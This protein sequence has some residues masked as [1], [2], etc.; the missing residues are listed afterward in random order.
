MAPPL[1]ETLTYVYMCIYYIYIYIYIYIYVHIYIST[2]NM[3]QSLVNYCQYLVFERPHLSCNDQ[4]ETNMKN[5]F[6]SDPLAG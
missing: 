6:V 3:G 4:S 2:A 5:T 1:W